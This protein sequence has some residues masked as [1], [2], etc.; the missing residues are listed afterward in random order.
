[1]AKSLKELQSLLR[2]LNVPVDETITDKGVLAARIVAARLQ[3]IAV[4]GG[5]GAG[6][7]AAREKRTRDAAKRGM[8][9]AKREE[10][11]LMGRSVEEVRARLR[12][13]CVVLLVLA[14]L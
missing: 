4:T 9:K 7:T 11:R 2:Y 13:R 6:A 1:M 5:I 12:E 10:Q 14:E 8:H 3:A